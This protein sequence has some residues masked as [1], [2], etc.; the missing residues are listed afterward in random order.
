M[1]TVEAELEQPAHIEADID[2][3]EEG[4]RLTISHGEAAPFVYEVRPVSTP[5]PAF[6]LTGPS[7]DSAPRNRYFRAEIF[8]AQGG[9]QYDI[10]GYSTDQV[11]ADIINHYD[12][13]QY[14]MALTEGPAK[15]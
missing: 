4:L 13:H 15:S 2:K 11:I 1:E 10:Y 8:L 9:R 14:Y 7:R 12:R 6:V 3:S 5:I